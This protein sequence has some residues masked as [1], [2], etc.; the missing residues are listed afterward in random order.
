MEEKKQR[1]GRMR[2]KAKT[3]LDVCVC[4]WGED[5]GLVFWWEESKGGLFPLSTCLCG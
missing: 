2:R 5:S 1:S 3:D 4:V